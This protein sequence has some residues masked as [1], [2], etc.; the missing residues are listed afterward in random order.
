MAAQTSAATERALRL[1]LKGWTPYAAAKKEGIALSTIY[2]ALKREKEREMNATIEVGRWFVLENRVPR[3]FE[4]GR[5]IIDAKGVTHIEWMKNAS[6]RRRRF[7]TEAG[8]TAAA[9]DANE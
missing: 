6:G 7:K 4:V 5:R 8:A 3:D 9:D 2:R 1:V